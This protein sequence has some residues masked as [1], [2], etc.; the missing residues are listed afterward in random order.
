MPDCLLLNIFTIDTCDQLVTELR[1][2]H[3]AAATVHGRNAVGT[4]EPAIRKATRVVASPATRA[5]VLQRLVD[6][7]SAIEEHFGLNLGEP[8]EPQ[9]LRYEAGD[10]FVAH[11]DGNT[12]LVFDDSRFRKISVVIFLNAQSESATPGTYGGGSLVLHGN[13][14]GSSLR[15][16]VAALPG[17]LV[18][19]RSETTHEVAPVTRGERYTVVSWYA[20][21]RESRAGQPDSIPSPDVDAALLA[22]PQTA[23]SALL[24]RIIDFIRSLGIEVSEGEMRRATLVPGIDIRRGGLV[25]DATR[26]DRKSTRLNSSHSDR[27]RMPSSA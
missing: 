11:Q 6:Q 15:S 10:H 8:E 18:A 22:R 2:I 5:R 24:A 1:S 13:C 14:P 21:K 7:K 16:P 20:L 25:V 9:F 12:Q 23:D 17:S 26:I 19:F 4:V 27:S 3:G